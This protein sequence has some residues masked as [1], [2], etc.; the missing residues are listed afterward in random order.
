M[1]LVLMTHLILKNAAFCLFALVY[2]PF[3][4]LLYFV[5]HGEVFPCQ[6]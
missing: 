3:I 4:L 1:F 6:E 2:I 5:L